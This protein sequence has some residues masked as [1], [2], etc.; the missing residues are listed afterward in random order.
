VSHSLAL[1][2]CSKLL[3]AFAHMAVKMSDLGVHIGV[4]NE[5]QEQLLRVQLQARYRL[6]AVRRGIEG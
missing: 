2:S 1:P 4:G 5:F 3:A 6:F